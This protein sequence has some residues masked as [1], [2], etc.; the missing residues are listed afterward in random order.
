VIEVA[1]TR[2]DI[3]GLLCFFRGVCQTN[4]QTG[5]NLFLMKE[6]SI[7]FPEIEPSNFG[8]TVGFVNHCTI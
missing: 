7:H 6:K 3:F 2:Q 8:A 5:P 4:V 1:A